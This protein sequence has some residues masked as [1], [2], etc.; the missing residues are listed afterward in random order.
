MDSALGNPQQYGLSGI[1][2]APPP[3]TPV[4]SLNPAGTFNLAGATAEGTTSTPQNLTVSNT[5]TGPLHVTAIGVNG[6]NAGEFS[7]A[8]S[9][10]LGT[11]VAAGASCTIPVTFAP[12]AAGIR[13]TTLTITD[14]A[15]N[16]PQMVTVNGTAVTAV[17]IVAA[18][19]ATLSASVSAGQTA[20]YNLQ[21]TPGAGFS[22]TLT[23]AC[24][25][26]PT[27]ANCSAPNVTVANGTAVN[28]TVT[29]T[30]SGSA[31][32][33]P[34]ARR[35]VRSRPADYMAAAMLLLMLLVFWLYSRRL[36]WRE[37]STGA[38]GWKRAVAL[39]CFALVVN[40]CGGGSSGSS[41]QPPPP[42]PPGVITPSG[43]Y[44]LTI[45]PSAT[46]VGSTKGLTVSPISL[47]L[48][49]K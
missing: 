9:N 23:F 27:G 19:G 39:A 4:V 14:D 2:V 38:L 20:Q 33:V 31:A 6:L 42:P 49:V 3:L 24:S 44:T 17:T 40:G 21:A 28:F 1:G 16:S 18:T 32:V 26:A 34:T 22:G 5:G 13:T 36:K 25:G 41:V 29:V 7:V 46:P 30:T 12:L 11:A 37:V 35:T 45:A 47:T 15:G 8:G 43:T 10:C 48:V